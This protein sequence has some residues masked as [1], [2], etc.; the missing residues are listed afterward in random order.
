MERVQD[1]SWLRRERTFKERLWK[2]QEGLGVERKIFCDFVY[3]DE[4][5][6]GYVLKG[7]ENVIKD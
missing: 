2:I 6:F 1:V 5:L 4:I 3:Y 7:K